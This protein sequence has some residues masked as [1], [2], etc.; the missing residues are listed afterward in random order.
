MAKKTKTTKAKAK[1]KKVRTPEEKAARNAKRKARR[2]ARKHAA[3]L[4]NT[5]AAKT[6]AVTPIKASSIFPWNE[7]PATSDGLPYSKSIDNPES[8]LGQLAREKE[9]M[10]AEAEAAKNA[11]KKNRVTPKYAPTAKECIINPIMS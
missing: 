1:V 5:I 9:R 2:E 11:A 3:Q 6:T 4:S 10:K 7:R 8:L